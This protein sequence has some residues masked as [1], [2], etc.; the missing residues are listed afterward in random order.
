MT[1]VIPFLLSSST[2]LVKM[3]ITHFYIMLFP[4]LLLTKICKAQLFLLTLCWLG[5]GLLY[6]V[7]CRP[8]AFTWDRT[9]KGE[10]W[11]VRPFWL[12]MSIVALFFDLTL[13]VL[14][15]PVV[16]RLKCG[17]WKKVRL[18]ALFSLGLL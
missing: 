2:F 1:I 18:T 16:W 10:C 6:F 14:P 11:D 3:S 5:G 12:G 9:L 13:V 4:H 15:I 8:L 7:M 17:T